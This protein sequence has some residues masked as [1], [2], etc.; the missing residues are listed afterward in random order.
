MTVSLDVSG[1]EART[2]GVASS[3]DRFLLFALS[4]LTLMWVLAMVAIV[5]RLLQNSRA[6][7]SGQ[8]FGW[9]VIALFGAILCWGGVT[10]YLLLSEVRERHRHGVRGPVTLDVGN[11]GIRFH[12]I[13]GPPRLEKWS[14]VRFPI[15]IKDYSDAGYQAQIQVARNTWFAI[16]GEAAR[17]IVST[18]TRLGLPTSSTPT[19]GSTGTPGVLTVISRSARLAGH[20]VCAA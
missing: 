19:V 18:A 7:L 13:R 8:N 16:T 10:L 17:T 2:F 20:A 3:V 5:P 12:W 6:L 9:W 4:G 11:E 1:A 14:G 15:V